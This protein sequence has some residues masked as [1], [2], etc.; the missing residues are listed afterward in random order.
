KLPSGS[1]RSQITIGRDRQG[2]P[3]RESITRPTQQELIQEL[4][5]IRQQVQAGTYVRPSQTTVREWLLDWLEGRRPHIE[6]KTYLGHEL[7]IRRHIL[8]EIG[9]MKLSDV[10]TR[11]IQKLINQKME[12]GL[13]VRTIKYI[14]T[15][16]NMAF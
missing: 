5:R 8:P 3:I 12:S 10:K 15:T 9:E 14:H 7:M 1:W 4:N 13:S 2:R 16:L 11:H 6:E